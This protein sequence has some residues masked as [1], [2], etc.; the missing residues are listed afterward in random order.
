L[1]EGVAKNMNSIG[2]VSSTDLEALKECLDQRYSPKG[3]NLE[4][5]LKL[6]TRVPA[7]WEK[8]LRATKLWQVKRTFH[9]ADEV[10]QKLHVYMS[11][12]V[13]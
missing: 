3:T 1:G 7:I 12:L 6:H 5:Q 2:L 8:S 10:L 4:R 13:D 9:E 11:Q